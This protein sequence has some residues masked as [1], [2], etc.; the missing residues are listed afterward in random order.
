MKA[1]LTRASDKSDANPS[2]LLVEAVLKKTGAV[3]RHA[4]AEST[5]TTTQPLSPVAAR[6]PCVTRR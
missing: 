4:P 1:P 5:T 3:R 2:A 6:K